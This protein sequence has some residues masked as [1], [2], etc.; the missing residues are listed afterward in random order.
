MA[1]CLVFL[2]P[3]SLVLEVLGLGD[4]SPLGKLGQLATRKPSEQFYQ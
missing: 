2:G 3:P 4:P 1:N